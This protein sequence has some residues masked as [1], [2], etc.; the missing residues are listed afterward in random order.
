MSWRSFVCDGKRRV[1][2]PG[3]H[4]SS[5]EDFLV[6]P[7]PFGLGFGSLAE[8]DYMVRL[9]PNYGAALDVLERHVPGYREAVR[10]D[11]RRLKARLLPDSGDDSIGRYEEAIIGAE[12]WGA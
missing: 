4:P 7:P 3:V 6:W 2:H 11:R 5:Y 1:S 9:S 10:R 8:L 12:Q